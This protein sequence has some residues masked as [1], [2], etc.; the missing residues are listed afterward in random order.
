MTDIATVPAV[1]PSRTR[2]V[3]RGTA[4]W[5]VRLLAVIGL[6]T[7]LR[8]FVCDITPMASGSMAPTLQG[9]ENGG[10]WV[11]TEKVSYW[12]RNP[13]RG[14][15]VEFH[16]HEGVQIMKRIAGLPGEKI[17]IRDYRLQIDG[18]DDAPPGAAGVKYYPYGSLG[19]GK[20]V[21]VEGGYFVLGDDSIDSDDSR[22]E[23]TVARERVRARACF[24]VWPPGRIGW[25]H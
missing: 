9:D 16:D 4:R 14:D 7:V 22:F 23:G 10:D 13:R 19:G 25:V 18:K 17:A 1:L 15:I 6:F 11:L 12:F 3:L 2:W 8:P 24:I 20:A 21:T 5:T